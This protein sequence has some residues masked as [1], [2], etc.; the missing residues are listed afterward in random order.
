MSS[1]REKYDGAVTSR[2]IG[3]AKWGN[4]L[5]DASPTGKHAST[6]RT[7]KN[8]K[9]TD[10]EINP[11][12]EDGEK[13]RYLI[14]YAD[15]ITLLLGLFI[16]LYAASNIDVLKY[17]K[18]ITAMGSVFGN[19]ASG[20]IV[21]IQSEAKIFEIS[22]YDKIKQDVN[23]LIKDNQYEANLRLEENERGITIHILEDIIF[24]SG[25]A[26]LN[27]NSK[28]VLSKLAAIIAVLPNDIRIEGHTDNIPISSGLFRSNWHLSVARALNTAYFL[29][30]SEKLSPD[31]VSIVGYAEYRPM[32]SNETKEGRATNRRVDLVIIKQ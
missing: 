20:K 31:K 26:E 25:S 29:I 30:D 18:M 2:S 17:E 28:L 23:Q 4:T 24:P 14:T 16:I 6:K 10:N 12:A 32:E 8:A 13:D 1:R 7:R 5:N 11:F 19:E 3:F 9:L 15:L 27:T 21:P 22:P